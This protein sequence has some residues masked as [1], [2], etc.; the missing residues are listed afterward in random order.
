MIF[1]AL[2]LAHSASG[3]PAVALRNSATTLADSSS[4]LTSSGVSAAD[5]ELATSGE[6]LILRIARPERVLRLQSG[7]GMDG[8]GAANRSGAGFG[9]TEKTHFTLA[10]EFSHCA[11]ASIYR[12]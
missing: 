3:I 1:A 10:H 6:N 7:D 8:L 4:R 2:A 5:A 12:P 9:Q 11:D